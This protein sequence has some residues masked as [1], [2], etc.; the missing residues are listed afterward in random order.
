MLP[1][2]KIPRQVVKINFN[3]ETVAN[4]VNDM[5]QLP[6]PIDEGRLG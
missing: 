4:G 3:Y 1:H 5:D 2:F 6:R